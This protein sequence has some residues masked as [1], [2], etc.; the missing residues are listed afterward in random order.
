MIMV[1]MIMMM[2]IFIITNISFG[3]FFFLMKSIKLMGYVQ[4]VL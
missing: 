3:S 4:A 2:M 1:M